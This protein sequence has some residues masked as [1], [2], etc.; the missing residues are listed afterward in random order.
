MGLTALRQI[1]FASSLLASALAVQLSPTRAA[2]VTKSTTDACVLRMEG[3]IVEGDL[4]RLTDMAKGAFKGID[5][6]SSSHDTLCLNS[7]GGSVTEGVKLATFIYKSG[8]G[9]V[10]DQGEQCYSICAIM[11]MMGIAQGPE[12]S[13][14]NRKLNVGGK[15]G[16]HRPYLAI[17]SD[18]MISVKALAVAHD[19]AVESITELMILANNQVP[20]SNSTMMKPDLIQAMLSHIGNDLFYIDTVDKAGR[21]EIDVVGGGETTGLTPPQAYYACENSFHWQVGLQGKDTDYQRLRVSLGNEVVTV[22]ADAPDGRIYAVTSEDEGYAEA[23]CLIGFKD[24]YVQG[25]GYNGSYNVSVGQGQCAV[26]NFGERAFSI[27]RVSLL[28]PG[29][30]LSDLGGASTTDDFAR[31]TCILFPATG[32][33]EQES[34]LLRFD[35]ATTADGQKSSKYEFTWPTGNKTI[36]QRTGQEDRINGKPAKVSYETGYQLC[37]TNTESNNRFCF[38][39]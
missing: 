30:A 1:M 31:T 19:A 37:A 33:M 29:L 6:E 34:C 8:V 18:E 16:F 28:R 38:K 23:R 2:E 35:N 36:L 12:V 24:G 4:Q 9:T 25:C 7:P 15:L 14:I 27:P 26:E 21:F 20:W 32:A 10:I 39:L 17:N 22:V 11:F 13:F 3:Q 5:G